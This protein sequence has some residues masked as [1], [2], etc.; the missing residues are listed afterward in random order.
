MARS[1]AGRAELTE[2]RTSP[3][4]VGWQELVALVTSLDND[5]LMVGRCTAAGG[6]SLVP[7]RL[8]PGDQIR[9]VSPA[10]TPDRDEVARGVEL[11]TSW[12][13]SVELGNHVF[14]RLGHYLASA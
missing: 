5:D 1:V 8:K 7:L 13:L 12:G 6:G 10:S 11:L 14:D 3:V 9:V 2:S 4:F